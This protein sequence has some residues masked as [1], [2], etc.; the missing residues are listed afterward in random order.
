MK[1]LILVGFAIVPVFI[2]S[3]AMYSAGL[4]LAVDAQETTKVNKEVIEDTR[5]LGRPVKY[6]VKYNYDKNNL[7]SVLGSDDF[8]IA[9]EKLLSMGASAIPILK[10]AIDSDSKLLTTRA[11][12]IMAKITGQWGSDGG[13]IWKKSFKDA[14]EESKKSGKPVMLLHLFGKLDEELC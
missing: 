4:L 7:L 11:K 6:V 14:C 10:R 5:I 1:K 8:K 9:Q 3:L 12:P 13:I 2:I